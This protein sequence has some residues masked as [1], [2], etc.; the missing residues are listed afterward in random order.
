MGGGGGSVGAGFYEIN[1]KPTLTKI[2]LNVLSFIFELWQMVRVDTFQLF[3]NT[4]CSCFFSLSTC[5]GRSGGEL[6]AW[7][8]VF[9][10]FFQA[11]RTPAHTPSDWPPGMSQTV[12]QGCRVGDTQVSCGLVS[13]KDLSLC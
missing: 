7:N 3:D 1:A 8:S 11:N 12:C 9:S 10:C 2:L 13:V 4:R 5:E 6:W